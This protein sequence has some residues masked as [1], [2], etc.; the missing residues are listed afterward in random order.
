VRTRVPDPVLVAL[1]CAAALAMT[2]LLAFAW[3]PVR[4]VDAQSLAGFTR[5]A[6]HHPR[7]ANA[8]S[9]AASG[10][11]LATYA[12]G[13]AILAAVA[14][15]RGRRR[16]AIAIPLTLVAAD[17]TAELLKRLVVQTRHSQLLAVTDRIPAS[18]WPSGH[19]AAI[20]TL[21]LCAVVVA[22][23]A[24]RGVTALLAAGAAIGVAYIVLMLGWHFPSDVVGGILVAG[25]WV[26]VM[27]AVVS[28][29]GGSARAAR[30]AGSSGRLTMVTALALVAA[31]GCGVALCEGLVAAHASLGASMLA[32]MI[33]IAVLVASLTAGLVATLAVLGRGRTALA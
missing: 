22:P 27:L 23:H 15:M 20:T 30:T 31:C 25:A 10:G 32:A 24:M 28:L 16:L 17:A 4:S 3:P 2:G 29:S 21:A 13:G 11:T 12:V 19:A 5:L 14:L 8:A 26:W 33:L 7:L 9:W 18:S 1:S 6:I